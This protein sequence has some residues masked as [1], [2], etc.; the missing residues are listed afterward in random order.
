MTKLFKTAALVLAMVVVFSA[1]SGCAQNSTPAAPTAPAAPA[2]TEAPAATTADAPA[3]TTADAPAAPAAPVD[4]AAS[5]EFTVRISDEPVTIS[6]WCPLDVKVARSYTNYGD[7][8]YYQ[9]LE[10][11]T[12]VHVDFTHPPVGAEPEQ[13]NLLIAGGNLPDIIW[14]QGT[15]NW[16]SYPGGISGALEDGVALDMVEPIQK[17]APNIQEVWRKFPDVKKRTTTDDG[18]IA[19]WPF[20]TAGLIGHWGEWHTYPNDSVMPKTDQI[21]QIYAAFDRA[22]NKTK[23]VTRVPDLGDPVDY[24]LGFHD[25]SFTE[26]TLYSVNW[27]FMQRMVNSGAED[28]WQTEP[29]GGEFRPEGQ[30]P[31]LKGEPL[32]GYD[33]YYECVDETHASWLIYHAAFTE[34]KPGTDEFKRVTDA[35]RYLGYDFVVTG[36][37]AETDGGN[38]D[39]TVGIQNRGVAPFYYDWQVV[40]ALADGDGEIATEAVTDWKLTELLPGPA[41]VLD[42]SISTDG[43]APGDYSLL[44]RVVNPMEGGKN[45]RFSNEA[46]DSVIRGW[47]ALGT[48]TVE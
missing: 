3:A 44:M 33:D 4:N 40:L 25:D 35:S 36:S 18:R 15:A 12:N 34:V 5:S 20:I 23:V 30:I 43:L 22:F 28:V 9:E 21:N 1:V 2:A 11:A 17:W 39:V 48:L 29:I 47:M 6:I 19:M 38:V 7:V 41:H 32:A 37:S 16:Y 24:N 8:L 27:H 46:Q 45:L 14:L 42:G 26:S 13:L 31:F 10:K